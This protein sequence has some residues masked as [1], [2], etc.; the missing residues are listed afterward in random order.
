L[1]SKIN[2]LRTWFRSKTVI[3]VVS[4]S[5]PS[6]PIQPGAGWISKCFAASYAV[7]DLW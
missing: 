3:P 4:V 5:P 7:L 6:M 2:I 1:F